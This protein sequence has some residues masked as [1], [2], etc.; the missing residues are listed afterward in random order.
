MRHA[1]WKKLNIDWKLCETRVFTLQSEIAVACI[2]GDLQRVAKL[3]SELVHSYAARALAV[4]K[5]ISN[6]GSKTPGIRGG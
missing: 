3:Q 5:V 6:P 1:L 4:R 2:K